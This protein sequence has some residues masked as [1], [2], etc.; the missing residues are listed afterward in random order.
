MEEVWKD[1]PDYEGIYKISNLGNVK[2]IDYY[3]TESS[4]KTRFR[5]GR[6]LTNKLP[7]GA[8][9]YQIILFK[10]NKAKLW[11]IH[12]LVAL[13]FV[14]NPNALP[15]VN[16]INHNKLD[17]RAENLEWCDK[18]YNNHASVNFHKKYGENL[19]NAKLTEQDVIKI[20]QRLVNKE[21]SSTLSK[22]FNVSKTTIDRIR[23]NK[24]WKRT[25]L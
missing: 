14:T 17:N 12:R 19:Y 2:S 1:I 13:A 21:P 6:L 18:S 7:Q 23:Q 11:R 4:G 22:E 5:K 25:K 8:N 3:I 16:H 24:I 15:E 20:K 10:Q 9:Y